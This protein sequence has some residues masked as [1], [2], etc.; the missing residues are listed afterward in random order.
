MQ[1]TVTTSY[2]PHNGSNEHHLA[3]FT[4]ISCRNSRLTKAA[5]PAKAFDATEHVQHNHTND[6]QLQMWIV[7][8]SN[9]M[10]T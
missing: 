6:Q 3:V 4:R 1:R 8:Q 2:L 9:I 7:N 5:M 10:L